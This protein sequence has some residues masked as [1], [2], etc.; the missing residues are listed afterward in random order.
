MSNTISK[1]DYIL[2]TENDEMKKGHTLRLLSSFWLE[3][4]L[5]NLLAS[6]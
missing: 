3:G 1:S 6:A 5:S 4:E 2:Y